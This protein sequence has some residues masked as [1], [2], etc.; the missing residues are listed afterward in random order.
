[1][2]LLAGYAINFYNYSNISL[3]METDGNEH[4]ARLKII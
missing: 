1:M 4:F 2:K 3:M